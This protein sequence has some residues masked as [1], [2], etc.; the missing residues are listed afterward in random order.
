MLRRV[1]SVVIVLGVLPAALAACGS[2]SSSSSSS[3]STTT[4]AP[5]SSAAPATGGPAKV[6]MKG[7]RF[8]PASITVKT[9]EPITWTNEDGVAHNVVAE[10]GASF[11][12]DTFDK[13]GT[14]EYTPKKSGTIKY[15]CTLHPGMDGTVQVTG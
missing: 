10:S 2:D 15:V 13:G 12:S 14:F 5:A 8:A 7:I 4:A 3:S 11:E 1:A 9:G 6:T